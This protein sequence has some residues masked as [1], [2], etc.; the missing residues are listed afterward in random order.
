[1]IRYLNI[2]L[3]VVCLETSN[4]RNVYS[5]PISNTLNCQYVTGSE[6]LTEV[7]LFVIFFLKGL[8]G[9]PA[10]VTV[11]HSALLKKCYHI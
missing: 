8:H 1:M 7:G 11:Q 10:G 3:T 9:Y 5:K 6:L 2:L 4:C